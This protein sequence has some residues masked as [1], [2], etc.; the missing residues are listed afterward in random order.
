MNIKRIVLSMGLGV[1][2]ALTA[3]GIDVLAQNFN[4]IL[5]GVPSINITPDAR[6]AGLGD[7]GTSTSPDEYSQY[8]NASKYAFMDSKASF[9]FSYTPWLSKLVNDIALYEIGG[10]Y[11][12]GTKDNQAISASLRFFD[13]GKV[14]Q[15]DDMGQ[16]LGVAHPNEMAIDFA[17][18]RKLS[19]YFSMA[20]G[21]RYIHSNQDLKEG[22]GS[23]H[24]FAMDISG[25]FN[26]TYSIFHK[27]VVWSAGFNVKNIG[28]KVNYG[29]S[30]PNNNFIPSNLGI[31][32]GISIAFDQMNTLAIHTEFNKLLVPSPPLYDPKDVDKDKKRENYFNTSSIGGI[33]KSFGDAP[34][35]FAEEM[36]EISWSI[37]TEYGFN[38][39]FFGRAGY[40]FMHPDKGNLQFMTLGAGFK[41]KVFRVDVSYLISTVQSNPLDQTFRLTVGLNISELKNLFR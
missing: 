13:M 9:N 27:D 35:G 23:G 15:W 41:H 1:T 8:W 14:D 34:K 25:F 11:K 4:P 31:G 38:N 6:A 30:G 16:S 7:Q 22:N 18:S 29:D 28:T 24:A 37:G 40:H 32:T 39:Q 26:K 5:T 17:Y 3:G 12:I 19:P 2:L 10:H 21:M 33:F 36:K 20:L